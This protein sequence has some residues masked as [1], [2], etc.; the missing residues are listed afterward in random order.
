MTENSRKRQMVLDPRQMRAAL[1]EKQRGRSGRVFSALLFG[2]I[3]IFLLLSILIGVQ[4]YSIIDQTRVAN[5]ETRL[6]LSLLANTVR[7]NDVQNAVSSKEGPEGP[8][9][10]FTEN[11]DSGAYETR[12]YLFRGNIVEEYAAANNDYAPGAARV[13]VDSKT[14]DF[15]ITKNLVVIKTDQ[16]STQVALRSE[17][18]GN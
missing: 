18:G 10:V 7:M 9:L 15:A 2:F 11:L 1:G 5:N 4:A 13:I 14:F 17:E 8:A 12:I 16:G 6:G 3:T